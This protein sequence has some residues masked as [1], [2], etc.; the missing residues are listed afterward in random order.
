MDFTFLLS[1]LCIIVLRVSC[2]YYSWAMCYYHLV[3]RIQANP[4]AHLKLPYLK[5]AM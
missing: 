4:V 5:A 1:S 2:H 3:Y